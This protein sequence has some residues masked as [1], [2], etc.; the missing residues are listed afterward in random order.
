MESS[1]FREQPKQF[2]IKNR[3]QEKYGI[4]QT[5]LNRVVD[6]NPLVVFVADC[7]KIKVYC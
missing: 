5:L 3:E 7:F 4:T 6:M 1:S 2:S